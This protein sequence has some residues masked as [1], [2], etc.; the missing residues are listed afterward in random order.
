MSER[1]YVFLELNWHSES[2]VSDY[3]EPDNLIYENSGHILEID[4]DDG[5]HIAGRFTAYYVDA[6]RAIN[7]RLALYDVM[8]AHSSMAEQIYAAIYDDETLGFNDSVMEAVDWDILGNNVL[9]LD[10]LELLPAYRGRKLGLR[11]LRHMILRFGA[12]AAIVAI[13]PFPL[14]F[15][16]EHA[17]GNDSEW[18]KKLQLQKFQYTEDEAFRKLSQYYAGLGFAQ[19]ADSPIMVLSTAW[20]MPDAEDED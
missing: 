20:Q 11:V 5:R 16:S 10:R 17:L 14:Q 15:E 1:D 12:G 18:R 2:L 7:E 3:P 4:E 19:L 8:D 6:D 9:I 13:K